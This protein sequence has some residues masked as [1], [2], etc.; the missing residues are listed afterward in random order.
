MFYNNRNKWGM[1]V[2]FLK[3]FFEECLQELI[4]VLCSESLFPKVLKRRVLMN[5][6]RNSL[7]SYALNNPLVL[8][9][10]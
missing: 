3:A 10:F 9:I 4:S 6:C 7:V 2:L 5:A 1:L 8:L